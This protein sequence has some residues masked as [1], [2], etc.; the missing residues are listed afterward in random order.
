M[1]AAER[2]LGRLSREEADV[3]LNRSL[4]VLVSILMVALTLVASFFAYDNATAAFFGSCR[5]WRV[6]GHWLLS[7]RRQIIELHIV[8]LEESLIRAG[9]HLPWAGGDHVVSIA[10][11]P[12][13]GIEAALN[14]WGE[15]RGHWGALTSH[16]GSMR[17]SR[18][19]TP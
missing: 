17:R 13:P 10:P 3:R 9:F 14:R 19:A 7:E 12:A 15:E 16:P 2:Y 11:A 18:R 1:P 5:A 6:C 4:A 8:D